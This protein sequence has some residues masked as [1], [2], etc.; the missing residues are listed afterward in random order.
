M[1]RRS[2]GG[3]DCTHHVA[4]GHNFKNSYNKCKERKKRKSLHPE[5]LLFDLTD[6]V[7]SV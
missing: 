5:R 1:Y 7:S 2:R 6:V 4:N 3:R